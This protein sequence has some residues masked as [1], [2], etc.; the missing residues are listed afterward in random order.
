MGWWRI[1]VVEFHCHETGVHDY[2]HKID[3]RRS[4]IEDELRMLSI[5]KAEV[6]I[7]RVPHS[8]GK[9]TEDADLDIRSTDDKEPKD[10]THK[11]PVQE[12]GD[13]TLS[14]SGAENGSQGSD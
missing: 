13:L 5:N 12:K 14:V 6:G 3:D 7:G 8:Q 10:E 9:A 2:K 4:P 11:E 1:E